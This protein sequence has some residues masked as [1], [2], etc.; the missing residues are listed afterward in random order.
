MEWPCPAPVEP[1]ERFTSRCSSPAPCDL[2]SYCIRSS[3]ISCNP[4]LGRRSFRCRSSFTR[5]AVPYYQWCG[6]C[7]DPRRAKNQGRQSSATGDDEET[8]NANRK[9]SSDKP[10]DSTLEAT[11][12]A[13]E[14]PTATGKE[15]KSKKGRKTKTSSKKSTSEKNPK[16]VSVHQDDGEQRKSD[17]KSLKSTSKAEASGGDDYCDNVPPEPVTIC[18]TICPS[19]HDNQATEDGRLSLI[20][21]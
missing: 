7:R 21:I 11:K 4:C 2:D 9:K 13:D 5:P 8:E 14:R 12:D 10:S 20:H 17:G 3:P 19:V 1:C 16:A 6:P 15:K 18:P